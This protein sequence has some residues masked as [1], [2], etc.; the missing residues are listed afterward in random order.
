[1]NPF[2]RVMGTLRGESVDRPP[3][4]AVLG[5]NPALAALVVDSATVD[6]GASTTVA[7]GG[8]VSLSLTVTTSGG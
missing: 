7:A 2:E 4:F 5:A 6:G 3:V 8:T 1:M